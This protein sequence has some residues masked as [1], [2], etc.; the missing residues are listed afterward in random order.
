[1]K[2]YVVGSYKDEKTVSL[3][4]GSYVYGTAVYGSA[5]Y[6]DVE[7]ITEPFD[8]GYIGK[9]IQFE[10][11]NNT[12]NQDFFVSSMQIDFKPLGRKPE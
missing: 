6:S 10:V 11:Y 8:I 12:A 9:R 4:G 2:I 7:L 5:Y 1:M 3:S